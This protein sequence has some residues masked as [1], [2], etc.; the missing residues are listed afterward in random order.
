M[1]AQLHAH[2][3]NKHLLGEKFYLREH[4]FDLFIIILQHAIWR[5]AFKETT[6]KKTNSKRKE[7]P[8][9][10]LAR[11]IRIYYRIPEIREQH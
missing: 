1:I 4:W 9:K 11:G 5:Q 2:N 3:W 7:R 10:I 6:M 8:K